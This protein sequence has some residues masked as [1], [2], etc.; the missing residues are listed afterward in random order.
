MHIFPDYARFWFVERLLHICIIQAKILGEVFEMNP[1]QEV[2][3]MRIKRSLERGPKYPKERQNPRPKAMHE[4][5]QNAAHGTNRATTS[6]WPPRSGRGG[7][8][9]PWWLPRA[10][11]GGCPRP[12]WPAV[13]PGARFP[14]R[15]SSSSG[16]F[17][18]FLALYSDVSRH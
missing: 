7:H 18:Y 14:S 2:W 17:C 10:D 5:G 1:T 8:H 11:R 13:T 4:Q 9:G 16:G 6:Q 3:A 15:D 12:W